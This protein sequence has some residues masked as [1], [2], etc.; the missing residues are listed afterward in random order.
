MGIV[1]RQSARNLLFTYA[2][3]LLGAFNTLALMPRILSREEMGLLNTFTS[4]SWVLANLC[5]F[6][7]PLVIIRFY[8]L[9]RGALRRQLLAF[10]FTFPLVLSSAVAIVVLVFPSLIRDLLPK[11]EPMFLRHYKWILLMNVMHVAF[12]ISA[13]ILKSQMRT[14]PP[15]LWRE[16]FLR[17]FNLIIYVFYALGWLN[18][19]ALVALFACSSV[20]ILIGLLL[21]INDFSWLRPSLY[22]QT[23]WLRYGAYNLASIG[24]VFVVYQ[25]DII[26]LHRFGYLTQIPIYTISM[27]VATTIQLPFRAFA[28]VAVPLVAQAFARH[29]LEAVRHLYRRSS[30][31][32]L[33]VGGFLSLLILWCANEFRYFLP[34]D[35]RPHLLQPLLFLVMAKWLDM[36]MG[37]NG[38]IINQSAHYRFD[39]WANL[40]LL[41]IGFTLN[42]IFIP[43]WGISGAALATF[44]S[45]MAYNLARYLYI[46][47]RFGVHGFDW[48]ALHIIGYYLIFYFLCS[49][50]NFS[51]HPLLVI[52]IKT[53]L[54]TIITVVWVYIFKPSGQALDILDKI[55]KKSVSF[56]YR[57]W[58]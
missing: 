54:I 23:E 5:L 4:Y 53:F 40:L 49:Q 48:N 24:L 27:F 45:I 29:D 56:I 55:R 28:S 6:G 9:S 36:A 18:Y 8:P 39:I 7:M 57:K 32:M 3:F 30:E 21:H 20:V 31:L 33:V 44:F 46:L 25:L 22:F 43:R 14:G 10:G 35:Y 15:V 11:A 50:I 42:V 47:R 52:V 41:V 26:M 12:E 1:I 2:G 37:L 16:L 17:I 51:G 19:D 58:D 13:S 38:A 34:A